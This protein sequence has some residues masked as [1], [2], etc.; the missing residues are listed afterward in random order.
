MS[1]TNRDFIE[2]YSALTT[3]E[4]IEIK[5]KGSLLEEAENAI[6]EVLNLRKVD[7]L[8]EVEQVKAQKQAETDD[9][10]APIGA[11]LVAK[12]VDVFVL[13]LIIIPLAQVFGLWDIAR[14]T[15]VLYALFMDSLPNGQSL[16]KRFFN[17]AVINKKTGKYCRFHESFIRNVTLLGGIFDWFFIFGKR[18]ERLGDIIAGTI[19][20]NKK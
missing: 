13:T 5:M 12:I 4:L 1:K 19:V 7:F 15:V 20:V 16:G 6:D 18:R 14:I 9:R 3:D 8:E 11:R 2:H 17:I 10:L